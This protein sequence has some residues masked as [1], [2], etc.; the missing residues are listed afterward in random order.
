MNNMLELEKAK[1]ELHKIE[2]KKKMNELNATN[3]QE[4]I[5]Q[6]RRKVNSSEE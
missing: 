2:E 6:M 3:N 1:K 4:L 5:E